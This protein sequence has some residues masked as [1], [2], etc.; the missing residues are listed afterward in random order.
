[1]ADIILLSVEVYV[2]GRHVLVYLMKV[3]GCSAYNKLKRDIY[4]GDQNS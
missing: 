3:D 1:M 2:Y 4:E